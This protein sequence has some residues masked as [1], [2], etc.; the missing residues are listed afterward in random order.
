MKK[1]I[2]FILL[3]IFYT[4]LISQEFIVPLNYNPHLINNHSKNESKNTTINTL[5]LP[6]KI[7]VADYFGYPPS[8][9]FTDST[10]FCNNEFGF[11]PFTIGVITLDAL[12]KNGQIYEHAQYTPFPADTLTSCYIRLDSFFVGIPHSLHISD[13]LYF[14]FAF[15][16]QGL[17]D[18]PETNDSLILE[19]YD[20]ENDMWEKVWAC[21]G[22]SLQN[23]IDSFGKPWKVIMIPIKDDK[24]LTSQFRF[25][26]RNLASIANNQIPN[27]N[28]NGDIWNIDYIYINKNRHW[29]DTLPVDIAFRGQIYSL[30]KKYVSMPWKQFLA[31]ADE[32]MI[33]N[34]SIPY[35]NFS[36]QTCNI[37]EYIEIIDLAN[38]GA[39]YQ[40]SLSALNVPPYTDT[41]FTRFTLPYTFNTISDSTAEFK[42]TFAI[43]TAT[44]PDTLNQND[45][46]KI[47]QRFYNYYAYDNGFP[48]AGY[49]LSG[50]DAKLAYKFELN[51][52]DTIR[53]IEFFLNSLSSFI[54]YNYFRLIIWDDING[55]PGNIIYQEEK[56]L[57]QHYEDLG[58]FYNFI[59]NEPVALPSGVF[60]V[61][62]MQYQ[63]S[64]LNIGFDGNN[65]AH[66]N[67]FYNVD[68]IWRN[69][70]YS[71]ALMIRPIVGNSPYP[72][73]YVP[74]HLN[75][76]PKI[77]I[78]PNP[79]Y[80]NSTIY[81]DAP[82]IDYWELYDVNGKFITKS[83]DHSFNINQPG[84][85][86][87]K[88]NGNEFF[89][90]IIY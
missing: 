44:I 77:N 31:N 24:F 37:T 17:S 2:N 53:S 59:L 69:S 39:P 14:S 30:L 43:N 4:T 68:G 88:I 42:I 3:L 49:C 70:Q 45:T 21:Q 32:E 67:I 61:G 54:D 16:P 36:D 34:F 66:N 5:N 9:Y 86:I 7:D 85:Y 18:A 51:V 62:F 11:Y 38:V 22:T 76:K 81:I 73:I 23:F 75:N 79:A 27:W 33:T 35:T 80:T 64:S 10:A 55:K 20:N 13:S 63:S 58:K 65:D 26:F 1:I 40:P 50:Y 12:D 74:E 89:K 84:F 87:I 29:H 52:P 15:Q 78:Y 25:R 82:F 28:S 46:I 72:Y 60:Y 48:T 57:P 56:L 8:E 47:Y 19:F 6:I 71:G 90:L 83:K 41:V